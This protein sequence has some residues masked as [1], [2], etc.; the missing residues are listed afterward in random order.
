M[1]QAQLTHAAAEVLRTGSPAARLT[2]VAIEVLRPAELQEPP[3]LNPLVY[4]PPV[5]GVSFSVAAA[6]GMHYATTGRVLLDCITLEHSALAE[7]IRIVADHS[8]FACTLET[9]EAVTFTRA[10]FDLQRLALS[11]TG[12]PTLTL[13]FS[14]ISGVAAQMLRQACRTTEPVILTLRVYASDQP[15]APAELPPT[16]LEVVSVPSLTAASIELRCALEDAGNRAYPRKT[17][18]RA[19]HPGLRP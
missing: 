6:E 18:T 15:Q 7:P 14:G 16:R 11:D 5:H 13:R 8:D 10:G 4:L 12:T 3:P 19:E 1:T 17:Y 9:G 2:H